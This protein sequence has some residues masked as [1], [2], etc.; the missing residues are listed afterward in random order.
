VS[1][2]VLLQQTLR[3]VPILAAMLSSAGPAMAISPAIGT[4][5]WVEGKGKL[6]G[7][8]RFIHVLA[9]QY[10]SFSPFWILLAIPRP[11]LPGFHEQQQLGHVV[12]D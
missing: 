3:S 11:D 10:P 2:Q 12:L 6:T 1:T 5:S 7:H 4:A 9:L 8:L